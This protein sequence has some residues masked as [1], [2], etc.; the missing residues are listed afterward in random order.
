MKFYAVFECIWLAT[1]KYSKWIKVFGSFFTSFVW[2]VIL[3]TLQLSQQLFYSSLK[4]ENIILYSVWSANSFSSLT[5]VNAH[6]QKYQFYS[7]NIFMYTNQKSAHLHISA[8]PLL[9]I[10]CCFREISFE[11]SWSFLSRYFC[12]SLGTILRHSDPGF[13]PISSLVVHF[14]FIY[15]LAK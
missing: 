6:L 9:A 5:W 3:I 4:S 8:D 15:A 12:G 14:L 2:F 13:G 10:W 1:D 11:N 7:W